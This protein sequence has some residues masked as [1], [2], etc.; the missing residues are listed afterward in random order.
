MV[1]GFDR[2]DPDQGPSPLYLVNPNGSSTPTKLTRSGQGPSFSPDGSQIIFQRVTRVEPV[3]LEAH[4][5]IFKINVNGTGETPLSDPSE[6]A[7]GPTWAPLDC[8][9]PDPQAKPPVPP[10]PCHPGHKIAYICDGDICIVSDAGTNRVRLPNNTG[11]KVDNLNWSPDGS[12]IAFNAH[13]KIFVI[14]PNGTH[15]EQWSNGEF[16]FLPMW[17][18]DGN[19]IAYICA[20]GIPPDSFFDICLTTGKVTP[21]PPPALCSPANCNGCCDRNNQCHL[22]RTSDACGS[23][24][25]QC[26]ACIG[27]TCDPTTLSCQVPP[28]MFCDIGTCHGCCDANNRC[29]SG[30]TKDFCGGFGRTCERCIGTQVCDSTLLVCR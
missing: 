26:T 15:L 2:N 29:H 17:A 21:P 12:L 23:G 8:T 30:V 14:N 4:F 7:S 25:F 10:G 11:G 5:Q 3:T 19:A 13:D 18:P 24:G 9:V 27:S 6:D 16:D 20:H 28:S 22:G 1:N